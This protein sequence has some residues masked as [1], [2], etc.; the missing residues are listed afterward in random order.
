MQLLLRN[1]DIST[2]GLPDPNHTV[3]VTPQEIVELSVLYMRPLWIGE[4]RVGL[5]Y[6]DVTDA[7]DTARD[8]ASAFGWLEF[9]VQ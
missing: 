5:G 7:I 2:V 6:R 1:F 9:V 3:S 4:L 8:D